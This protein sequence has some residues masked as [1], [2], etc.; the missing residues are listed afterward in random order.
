MKKI[1]IELSF[2][3]IVVGLWLDPIGTLKETFGI[4]LFGTGV[5][6]FLYVTFK[7]SEL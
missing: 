7:G 6:L 5:I 4:K 2:L 1:L 3:L